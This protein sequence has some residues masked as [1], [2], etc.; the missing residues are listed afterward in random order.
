MAIIQRLVCKC[1][2]CAHEWIAAKTKDNP[3]GDPAK[4]R[5]CAACKTARWNQG[6]PSAPAEAFERTANAALVAQ[7]FW[8]EMICRKRGGA[9]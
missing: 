5:R 9:Q 1:A 7:K 6:I 8:I 3:E 4:V 2:I